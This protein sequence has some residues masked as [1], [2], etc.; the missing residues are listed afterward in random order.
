[1][2]T[3]GVIGHLLFSIDG[4]FELILYFVRLARMQNIISIWDS[5]VMTLSFLRVMWRHRSRDHSNR[6]MWLISEKLHELVPEFNQT[7]I[8]T[9]EEATATQSP[10]NDCLFETT[11]R[12]VADEQ[13]VSSPN[14]N[15]TKIPRPRPR[16]WASYTWHQD[17]DDNVSR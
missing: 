13:P 4:Q 16:P 9:D 3:R 11:F 6:N 15:K 2:G 10:H 14:M 8:I 17:Q 5:E 7:H 1:M 12:V